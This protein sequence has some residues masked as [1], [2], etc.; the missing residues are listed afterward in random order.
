VKLVQKLFLEHPQSVGESYS[1]HFLTAARFG[2]QMLA[3][4]A[5]C[6]VHAVVPALFVSSASA[7]VKALYLRMRSRQPKFAARPPE[8]QQSAWLPEYEI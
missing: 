7:R 4:G 8:F 6:L 5:A 3:G 1:Q 2:A